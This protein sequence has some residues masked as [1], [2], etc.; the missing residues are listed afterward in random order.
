MISFFK[1]ILAPLIESRYSA[2]RV[3]VQA[4]LD[5]GYNAYDLALHALWSRKLYYLL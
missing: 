4:W 5:A 3:V 1:Y 2:F